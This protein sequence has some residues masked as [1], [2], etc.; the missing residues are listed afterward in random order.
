MY[1]L[2][3]VAYAGTE[4]QQK[5]VRSVKPLDDWMMLV[6]FL[7]G[8]QRLFDASG[9]DTSS[10]TDMSYMFF[11]A[12]VNLRDSTTRII[13]LSSWDVKNVKDFT[14]MFAASTMSNIFLNLTGWGKQI[15]PSAKLESMLN[16]EGDESDTAWEILLLDDAADFNTRLLTDTG[17]AN[18]TYTIRHTRIV[19]QDEAYAAITAMPALSAFASAGRIIKYSNSFAKVRGL[20]KSSS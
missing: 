16:W 20:P 2:G 3:G 14:C 1:I 19:V 9:L 8:E 12:N 10:V 6:T 15:S 18:S 13:D 4:A 7:S 11:M 5:L 17:L